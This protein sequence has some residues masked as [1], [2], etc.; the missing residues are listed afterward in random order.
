[1][2]VP[3]CRSTSTASS[4]EPPGVA[5]VGHDLRAVRGEAFDEGAAEAAGG[6]GDEDGLVSDGS[7]PRT[8]TRGGRD[9]PG[10]R[11]SP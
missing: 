8:T 4:S 5:A 1:M 10:P 11:L 9:I 6:P 3:V 2:L 7:H